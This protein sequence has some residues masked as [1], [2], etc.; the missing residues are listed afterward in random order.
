MRA[1]IADGNYDAVIFDASEWNTRA[2][3]VDAIVDPMVFRVAD[4]FLSGATGADDDRHLWS[5]LSQNITSLLAFFDILTYSRQ[6]PLIDYGMTFMAPEGYTVSR[7]YH[8][9]NEIQG[10]IAGNEPQPLLS[11]HIDGLAHQN[12]RDDALRKLKLHGAVDPAMVESVNTE[13]SSFDHAWRPDL[14]A[15]D[16]RYTWTFDSPERRVETFIYGGLL[17]GYIADAAGLPHLLQGTRADLEEA[18]ALGAEPAQVQDDERLD[19]ALGEL[20]ATQLGNAGVKTLGRRGIPPVLPYLLNQYQPQSPQELILRALELRRTSMMQ[21][22]RDWKNSCAKTFRETFVIQPEVERDI[23]AVADAIAARLT[24][25]SHG[26]TIMF[27]FL[28]VPNAWRDRLW[29]WAL[30][31]VPGRNHVKMLYRL[32]IADRAVASVDRDESLRRQLQ[33]IWTSGVGGA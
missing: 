21:E 26:F 8:M 5:A 7:L 17:F 19:E 27:K 15:L 4:V 33:A 10:E 16:Q 25:A 14:T 23:A 32:Q 3:G 20:L 30:S 18:V 28:P 22:F 11:V 13:L 6:L 12:A 9:V 1:N 31:S 29:N 2:P 24:P